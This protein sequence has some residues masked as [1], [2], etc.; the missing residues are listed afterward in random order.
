MNDLLIPVLVEVTSK[1]NVLSYGGI[2]YPR[3][4]G[5][6]AETSTNK[7]DTSANWKFSQ[8]CLENRALEIKKVNYYLPM[9]N[10]TFSK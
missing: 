6:V 7:N 4:L 9:Y 8:N 5:A 1:N 10:V 3:I 2:E